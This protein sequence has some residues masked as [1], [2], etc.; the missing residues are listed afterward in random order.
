MR[1]HSLFVSTTSFDEENEVMAISCTE[2]MDVHTKHL[3]FVTVHTSA[4]LVNPAAPKYLTPTLLMGTL[5]RTPAG[6]P[7][8]IRSKPLITQNDRHTKNES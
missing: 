4:Q 5:R 2:I 1:P 3:L 8:Y 7:M 6:R